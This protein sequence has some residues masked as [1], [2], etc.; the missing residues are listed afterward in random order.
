MNGEFSAC[1]CSILHSHEQW[2]PGS[3]Y[4]EPTLG[5]YQ[6]HQSSLVVWLGN[7]EKTKVRGSPSMHLAK[8]RLGLD[9][10][11]GAHARRT[12]QD[13]Y[14]AIYDAILLFDAALEQFDN[15]RDHH[16]RKVIEHLALDVLSRFR[17]HAMTLA[18]DRS[19]V[20]SK[21]ALQ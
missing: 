20:V 14:Q 1:L 7:S 21:K 10:D 17:Q 19:R 15:E 2:S 9:L 12:D 5:E 3:R 18:S 6:L 13:G 16:V 4:E 11:E 8:S